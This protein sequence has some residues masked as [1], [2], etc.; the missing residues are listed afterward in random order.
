MIGSAPFQGTDTIQVPRIMKRH[1]SRSDDASS[2]HS[3]DS[4]VHLASDQ[5]KG[6][7]TEESVFTAEKSKETRINQKR[8][9]DRDRGQER[10]P[11]RD[12]GSDRRDRRNE[13]HLGEVEE[14]EKRTD[15]SRPKG[16]NKFKDKA[17]DGF[18]GAVEK[19]ASDSNQN[20]SSKSQKGKIDEKEKDSR[21]TTKSSDRRDSNK[22]YRSREEDRSSKRDYD[23]ERKDRFKDDRKNR[24]KDAGYKSRDREEA[25]RSMTK[26]DKETATSSRRKDSKDEAKNGL[27]QG[28]QSVMQSQTAEG[29]SEGNMAV[30]ESGKTKST[31]AQRPPNREDKKSSDSYRGKDTLTK[32]KPPPENFR[33]LEKS[34]GKGLS[35][36]LTASKSDDKEKQLAKSNQVNRSDSKKPSAWSQIVSGE[37]A[38]Q[39]TASTTGKVEAQPKKSLI[40]IQKEEE[41][42]ENER[43]SNEYSKDSVNEATTGT[44]QDDYQKGDDYDSR[45][46]AKPLRGKRY[47][48][49]DYEDRGHDDR[50]IYDK[51]YGEKRYQER[52]YDDR[53]YGDKRYQDKQ[54]E[55]R[56]Y[57][58]RRSDDKRYEE[59]TGDDRFN[60]KSRDHCDDRFYDKRDYQEKRENQDKKEY[61]EKKRSD[62]DS[63]KGDERSEKKPTDAES[64]VRKE[65][66]SDGKQDQDGVD[67]KESHGSRKLG[68]EDRKRRHDQTESTDAYER[69]YSQEV[70]AEE[71]SKER[72]SDSQRLEKRHERGRL[73]ERGRGIRGNKPLY[74]RGR[75]RG[76]SAMRTYGSSK[77]G[78]PFKEMNRSHSGNISDQSHGSSK[79]ANKVDASEEGRV[80]VSNVEELKDYDKKEESKEIAKSKENR[81][82]EK[83]GGFGVP[84]RKHETRYE[85]YKDGD[86]QQVKDYQDRG[87]YN[88][89]DR[90]DNRKGRGGYSTSGSSRHPSKYENKKA[91]KDDK[92]GNEESKASKSEEKSKV[93]EKNF[94][95][96]ECSKDDGSEY[97]YDDEYTDE[98]DYEDQNEDAEGTTDKK[99]SESS[100]MYKEEGNRHTSSRGAAKGQSSSRGPRG[101]YPRD[102]TGYEGSYKS[103]VPPRFQRQ[104]NDTNDQRRSRGVHVRGSRGRG[105]ASHMSYKTARGR[106]FG[107]PPSSKDV[108]SKTSFSGEKGDEETLDSDD[109]IFHS[110]DDSLPSDNEETLAKETRYSRD[111]GTNRRYSGRGRSS[112]GSSTRGRGARHGASSDHFLADRQQERVGHIDTS[113]SAVTLPAAGKASF[114]GNRAAEDKSRP[115]SFNF[116][117]T[118]RGSAST[119]QGADHRYGGHS[120]S[121][122]D[123]QEFSEPPKKMAKSKSMEKPDILRQYD[124]NNIASVVCIDDMPQ[125]IENAGASSQTEEDDGF[126][127]VTSRKAQKFLREKQ[128]EEEKRKL[129]EEMNVKTAKRNANDGRDSTNKPGRAFKFVDHNQQRV[130]QTVTQATSQAAV[131]TVSQS[132]TSNAAMAAVGG[133]EPAQALLRGVQMVTPTENLEAGKTAGA[134]APPP[135]MNAW[136]RPL[137]FAASLASATVTTS[138]GAQSVPDPKAVGTGKPNSSPAKQVIIVCFPST[139]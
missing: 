124:V 72:R 91:P 68:H 66:V 84:S 51:R 9:S 54:Y 6:K 49:K 88:R 86:R 87:S 111:S 93:K 39:G 28:E 20:D 48:E 30:D 105:R 35:M 37:T 74:S 119:R 121:Q 5:E 129:Q 45:R 70:E 127:Q 81:D 63:R 78:Y 47:D 98:E 138:N 133:W 50:K 61:Q 122:P 112:R 89:R 41:L 106:G 22:D 77:E 90:S 92:E 31:E 15:K 134:P 136:K 55:D 59:R 53:R 16:E 32:S 8:S 75:G 73:S 79:E 125:N 130:T 126:V 52:Q 96:K 71:K 19:Q 103:G 120:F 99:R 23:D 3:H 56:R 12:R 108:K 21:R 117:S 46:H 27:K 36:K 67:K 1:D 65:S 137:S 132:Q 29:N 116:S 97:E 123:S 42:K 85:S 100:D 58:E 131:T 33:R 114:P 57:S 13:R 24:D 139:E 62:K 115:Y 40:E 7:D 95:E 82:P 76:F 44:R 4:W 43:D 38:E 113:G 94:P 17:P 18:D 10:V 26:K 101:R 118:K 69:I 14:T 102:P 107:K 64:N 80:D 128:K 60:R 83:K 2:V 135:T 34:K 110:A 109:D 25:S 11:E 104:R